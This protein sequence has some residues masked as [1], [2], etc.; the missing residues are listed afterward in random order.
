MA[1]RIIADALSAN[2]I[3]RDN[4]ESRSKKHAKYLPFW[5]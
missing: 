5:A 1:S 2:V 3:K 4:P